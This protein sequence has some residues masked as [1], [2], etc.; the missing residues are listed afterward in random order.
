[1]SIKVN[2]SVLESKPYKLSTQKAWLEKDKSSVLK[3]DWNESTISPS[4]KVIS[5]L[6]NLIH[7]DHLNWYPNTNNSKL[8]ELLAAYC[9]VKTE[10]VQYFNGSDA[11]HEVIF[12][13]FSSDGDILTI[14]GPTYDHPRSVAECFGLTLDYFYLSKKFEFKLNELKEHLQLKRSNIVYICSPNNPTGNTYPKS[15]IKQLLEDFPDTLFIIDEAY[16][17]FS[18]TTSEDLVLQNNNIIITRT[19][20]KAFGLASMRLGYCLSS[21]SNI[22]MMNKYRNPKS[23]NLFAQVAGIESLN[24]LKYIEQYVN[25]VKKAKLLFINEINLN[26]S[27]FIKPISGYGNFVLFENLSSKSSNDIVEFF[28]SKKIF[29]RDYG[30]IKNLENHI[31]VTIGNLEQTLKLISS[32]KDCFK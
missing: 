13:T 24:D 10:N 14:I 6:T 16:R 12:K 11:V 32:F 28:E 1:M 21:V 7:S 31:R 15:T 5:A 18:N 22:S 27:D 25:E 20:S 17:E 29:I 9:S 2:K 4:P 30:H 3:L 19:F 8:I 23:I 26:L